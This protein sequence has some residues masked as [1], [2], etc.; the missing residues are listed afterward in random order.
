MKARAR[1]L[2]YTIEESRTRI[3]AYFPDGS[4][5][6]RHSLKR[7]LPGTYVAYFMA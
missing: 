2:R 7:S 1:Y 6:L 4:S 5:D 3:P